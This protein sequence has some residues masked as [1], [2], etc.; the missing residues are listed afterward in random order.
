MPDLEVELAHVVPDA[1][2]RTVFLRARADADP[3]A[4]AGETVTLKTAV[5]DG[6]S[7]DLKLDDAS[8]ELVRH[9]TALSTTDF[10][11]AP[12]KVTGQYYEEMRTLFQKVTGGAHVVMFH[13]QVRSQE[14]N[15]SKVDEDGSFNTSTS[16]QPYAHSIHTDSSCFHSEQL[17]KSMVEKVPESCR[18]GRFMYVN[19]WRNIADTPIVDNH[20]AVLDE[21]SLV[22]PDDYIQ[23]DLYGVGYEVLQYSLSARNAAQHRWYYFPRMT[24]DEV[25]IFKQ[26]DSDPALPGRLCFH[27]A[28]RDHGAPAGAPCRQSIEARAFVFFPDHTPNTCPA[29]PPSAATDG[30]CDEARA[31]AAVGKIQDGL[32][33]VQ[34]SPSTRAM[35]VTY[36]AGSYRGGGAEAVLA[37]FAEDKQGHFGLTAASAATKARAVELLL[38]AGAA[39]RVDAIFAGTSGTALLWAQ[40]SQSRVAAAILGAAAALALRT[41]ACRV[42]A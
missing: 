24:K 23:Q 34:M 7:Q 29:L 11:E 13:H 36:L 41:L 35:V 8:F 26:W 27:T 12:E 20:L 39:K 3:P 14:K 18:R 21:R 9:P 5:R 15:N 31:H 1:R 17:F 10:F 25:L 22:K 33:Y 37:E 4:H 6:R 32:A 40:L 16:V 19:A 2:R 38:A 42:R 28:I 30:S